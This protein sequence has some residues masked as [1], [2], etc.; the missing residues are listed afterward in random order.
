[1]TNQMTS[2]SGKAWEA[3]ENERRR[4]RLIRRGCYTAWSITFFFVAILAGTGSVAAPFLGSVLFEI[5]RSVAY[6]HSPNTWQLALGTAML[7]VI[8]FLPNGLW[9]IFATRGK[10]A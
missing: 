7:L 8:M 9:S 10:A 4:D 2:A 3:I 5:V 6:Q 1:M